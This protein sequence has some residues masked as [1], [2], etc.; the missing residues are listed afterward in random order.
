LALSLEAFSASLM[1]PVTKASI[2]AVAAL[3]GG[4]V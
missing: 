3:G 4:C 1:G 2:G